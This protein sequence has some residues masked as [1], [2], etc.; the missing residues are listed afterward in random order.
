MKVLRSTIDLMLN[1]IILWSRDGKCLKM[2][3]LL[4]ILKKERFSC[5][6]KY[7]NLFV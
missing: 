2:V 6:K 1:D 4:N 3:V 7:S 5:T